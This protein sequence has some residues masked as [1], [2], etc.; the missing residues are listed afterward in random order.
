MKKIAPILLVL[1]FLSAAP[2]NAAT[3]DVE[4]GL[5]PESRFYWF[6]R[7]SERIQLIFTLNPQNKSAALSAIGLERL[8]EAEE[9]EDEATVGA[10]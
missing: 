10:D 7:L 4:A 3:T 8:A 9:V 5:T 2:A 1:I 6:D